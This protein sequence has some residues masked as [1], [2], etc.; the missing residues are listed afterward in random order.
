MKTKNESLDDKLRSTSQDISKANHIIQKLQSEIA[1]AKA[2]SKTKNQK[3]K[4]QESII[5]ERQQEVERCKA[6]AKS[7]LENVKEKGNEAIQLRSKLE[8]NIGDLD[9]AHDE[10]SKLRQTIDAL[11]NELNQIHEKQ[12]FSFAPPLS[13]GSRPFINSR[14]SKF[15]AKE[16]LVSY[17]STPPVPQQQQQQP[18]SST[19]RFSSEKTITF[20]IANA[21][22]DKFQS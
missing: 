9:K 1:K 11:S 20:S 12:K 10:I 21:N 4:Q 15:T 18:I 2:K 22:P 8:S 14:L 13:T 6:E 7:V 3:I 17:T 16:P 5:I 19:Q